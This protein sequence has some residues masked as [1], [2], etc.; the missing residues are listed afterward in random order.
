MLE[1][2]PL[3]ARLVSTR[4]FSITTSKIKYALYEAVL[5]HVFGGLLVLASISPIS[6][7]SPS[8]PAEDARVYSGGAILITRRRI[9]GFPLSCL[10]REWMSSGALSQH[11]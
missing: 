11:Q 5:D 2:T 8:P 9:R 10:K 4:R 1:L 7:E 3:R 6:G